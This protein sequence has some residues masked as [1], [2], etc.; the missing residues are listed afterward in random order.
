MELLRSLPTCIDEM[1]MAGGAPSL[2]V[3]DIPSIESP[4]KDC[5][6]SFLTTAD[7]LDE[8]RPLDDE[9]LEVS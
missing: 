4:N 9:D 8:F 5:G 7:N 1:V 3:E 6:E 2:H